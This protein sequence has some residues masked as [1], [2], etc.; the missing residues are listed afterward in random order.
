VEVSK[1]D[2]EGNNP[3]MMWEKLFSQHD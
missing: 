1:V 2:P 3:Q